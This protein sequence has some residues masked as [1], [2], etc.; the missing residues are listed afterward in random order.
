MK[1]RMLFALG[2]MLLGSS[3]LQGSPLLPTL[4]TTGDVTGI[5]GSIVGWGLSLAP[6]ANYSLS[7]ISSFLEDETNSALG[8]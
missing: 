2:T 1:P 5:P 4:P 7:A 3:V 6:D 8:G